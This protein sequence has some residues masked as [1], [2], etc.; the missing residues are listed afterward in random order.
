MC[1]RVGNSVSI[2]SLPYYE[3]NLA[4]SFFSNI[5]SHSQKICKM[6]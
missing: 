2:E 4:D 6:Q 3:L 1:A 5:H